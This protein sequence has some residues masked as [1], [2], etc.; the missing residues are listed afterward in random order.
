MHPHP[1]TSLP[2]LRWISDYTMAGENT[3]LR[4]K[5]VLDREML[6]NPQ[7]TDFGVKPFVLTQRNQQPQSLPSW[8][9]YSKWRPKQHLCDPRTSRSSPLCLPGAASVY[10]LHMREGK[11]ERTRVKTDTPTVCT[12]IC[13]NVHTSATVL[14]GSANSD[15]VGNTDGI[16]T[17]SG[18]QRTWAWTRHHRDPLTIEPWL[19]RRWFLG[20]N[21]FLT[22]GCRTIKPVI[23]L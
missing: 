12:A 23:R 11:K 7:N 2:H 19:R 4:E 1:G 22:L 16:K 18:S 15:K 10:H 17:R 8:L 3:V 5:N 9:L 6:E 13:V 14:I 20:N 21:H